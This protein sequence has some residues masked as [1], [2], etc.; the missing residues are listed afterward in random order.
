[1]AFPDL[2]PTAR[3]VRLG[4][5]PVKSF[6]SQN[7][8]EY[9]V[10]YG[11]KRVGQE[12]ELTFENISDSNAND[13]IGHYNSSKGT[14]DT[15]TIEPN[16]RAGWGLGGTT[17][18]DAPNASLYRYAEAPQITSVRPGRSTVTVRLVS[19]LR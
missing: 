16:T 8:K 18:F 10:V 6:R 11:D 5:W 2:K 13:F 4:D 12:L 9:R 3:S 14:Y 15:F 17:P 7:G 19:V 1:M